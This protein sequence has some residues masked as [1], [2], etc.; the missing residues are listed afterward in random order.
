MIRSAQGD[1]LFIDNN[2]ASALAHTEEAVRLLEASNP[3]SIHLARALTSL[4]RLHRLQGNPQEAIALN[5]RAVPLLE[6]A[7]DFDGAAQALHAL[8]LAMLDRTSGTPEVLDLMDRAVELAKKGGRPARVR[9][10]LRERAS[11]EN[12][13]FQRPAESLRLLDLAEAIPAESDAEHARTVWLRARVASDSGR[14]AE[15]L[16]LVDEALSR[17][18]DIPTA[19]LL[20]VHFTRAVILERLE[21]LSEAIESTSRAVS[22]VETLRAG[23][24]P[25][26]ESRSGF[27]EGVQGVLARH[28]RLL[29][30]AGRTEEALT[31]SEQARARAFVDLLAT[32]DQIAPAKASLLSTERPAAAAPSLAMRG[33]VRPQ[34]P[35]VAGLVADIRSRIPTQPRSLRNPAL[36]AALSN[37]P[38]A[39]TDITGTAA[40]FGTHL[41]IYWVGTDSTLIWVVTPDGR[42]SSAKSPMGGQRLNALVRSTWAAEAPASVRSP[43]TSLTGPPDQITGAP[44]DDVETVPAWEPAL[45]GDGRLAFGTAS[46]QAFRELHRAL[47]APVQESLP[48]DKDALVTI[49]PHG[50]LFRLSFAS[51][52][53]PGGRY[54]IEEARLSYTPSVAALVRTTETTQPMPLKRSVVVADPQLPPG[55]AR[56]ERLARLPG[57]SAEGRAVTRVLGARETTLLSGAT[58]NE[59]EVRKAL[60]DARVVH[61]ATHGVVRDDEPMAS[62]LA[63][64]GSAASPQDDGRLTTAEVYELSL[65][66]DLVVLSACRSA[67]GPVTGDGITGL[68]RAFFVAGSRSVMAS[69]WDLPD[70]V[71]APLL[72]R[73]YRE[74]NASS[75]KA[76]ALRRAQLH[77]IRELRAGRM[78]VDTPAGRFVIPEHPSLWAGLVLVGEP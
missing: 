13:F 49:V 76:E 1:R 5:R 51:L 32:R 38:A 27:A 31:A 22:M 78:A 9:E 60:R 53:S 14:Q 2:Y 41:L 15:A 26:D 65:D 74:W 62:F 64:G 43:S 39:L 44:G 29:A 77:V 57:A 10:L 47:I 66:A 42:I 30:L 37:P 40:K 45:R 71:T 23:L 50:S 3:K 56:T 73:F 16:A 33:P 69:L 17:A 18:Q 12:D 11:I 19:Q 52:M 58:A 68:T 35:T 36:D 59:S 20:R 8:A 25:A 54:L 24:V 70:I 67:V 75:T 63:L 55:M 28:V 48:A 4:G 61:F 72:A 7:R 21:R 46:Q 34:L 6:A